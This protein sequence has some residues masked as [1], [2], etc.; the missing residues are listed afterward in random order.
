MVRNSRQISAQL[1]PCDV[2]AHH[3]DLLKHDSI[4]VLF[5]VPIGH[6]KSQRK[7]VSE[8]NSTRVDDNN[9]ASEEKEIV[10]SS[11][12][13]V[14]SFLS[15]LIEIKVALT[16]GPKSAGQKSDYPLYEHPFFYSKLESCEDKPEN[17]VKFRT[18]KWVAIKRAIIILAFSVLRAAFF[19]KRVGLTAKPRSSYWM[20]VGDESVFQLMEWFGV[21]LRFH[22]PAN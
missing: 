7:S 1:L 11:S 14:R 22:W 21:P 6:S 5:Q 16:C 12:K 20:C 3:G 15:F 10:L 13:K 18:T 2:L 8:A 4:L 19:Y 9:N 17:Q